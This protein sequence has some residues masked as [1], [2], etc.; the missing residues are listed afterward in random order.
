M[1]KP[2]STGSS[3]KLTRGLTFVPAA[4][5][6][7][8]SVIGTGIFLKARTMTCNVGT[9]GMVLLAY[10]V[11][12]IFSLAGA[13][14]F[15][16]LSA[17][18]PRS[19]GHYNYLGAAF[20]RIWAFLFGWMQAFIDTAGS[21]AAGAIVFVIFFNDLIGG[22]L[23]PIVSQLIAVVVLLVVM[24]LNL[25][26]VHANGAV[27]TFITALKV[28]MVFGI[29]AA[30]FLFSDGSWANFGASGASGTCEGIPANS[31]LGIAGFGA[32]VV[33]ALW[34]YNGWSA[35]S[36]IAEE[37]KDPGKTLPRA[38]IWGCILIIGLYLLITAGYF[39]VLAP[40]EVA[41]VPETASVS[42]VVLAK[43]IG[44]GGASLMAAGLLVSQFGALHANFLTGSRLPFA[45]ARD[46]MLPRTLAKVSP[47]THVPTHAVVLLVLVAIA[48]ALLGTFDVI[49]DMIVMAL[50]FFNGLGIAAIYVLRKKLPDAKRP[51]R[52]WGYPWVPALFL[53]ATLYLM[54][55]TFFATPWRAIAG[56]G[57][58]LLGLPV[59]AYYARGL[60]P[61]R[62]EDWLDQEQD[63]SNSEGEEIG[64]KE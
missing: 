3:V 26:T 56:L 42:G 61:D 44:A 10:A 1:A 38:L 50:L 29:G 17:M 60:A 45:M 36:V 57:I 53:I 18:M 64:D 31:M 19:G 4:A 35:V 59:Y 21:G 32:A 25:T 46:G 6:I 11:A 48:L 8:T 39:Y 14:T 23:S 9:P 27:A 2:A 62:I 33:G 54:I 30:A 5:I 47:N 7:I 58:V 12:G 63:E 55:N 34:S 13:L 49:T 37:V 24:A 22:S 41:S 40:V 15:A 52:M 51:Y 20:G 28:L 16:E 43:M